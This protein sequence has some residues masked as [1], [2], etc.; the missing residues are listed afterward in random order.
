V[1]ESIKKR[2]DAGGRIDTGEAVNK[3]HTCYLTCCVWEGDNRYRGGDGTAGLQR[4]SDDSSAAGGR[5]CLPLPRRLRLVGSQASKDITPGRRHL[6]DV[7]EVALRTKFNVIRVCRPLAP[8]IAEPWATPHA[9]ASVHGSNKQVLVREPIFFL[10]CC[11]GLVPSGVPLLPTGSHT[12]SLGAQV[13]PDSPRAHQLGPAIH[14]RGC[15]NDSGRR[16]SAASA[17]TSLCAT[18]QRRGGSTS[19]LL[20]SPRRVIPGSH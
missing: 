1:S 16:A 19:P 10:V 15:R 12:A 6:V 18:R 11:P 13:T 8:A 7:L 9:K 2:G 5:W 17:T 20:P 14:L 3:N 4:S